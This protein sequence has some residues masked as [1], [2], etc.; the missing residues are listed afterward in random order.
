MRHLARQDARVLP[1]KSHLF[2]CR[3]GW[4]M[5]SKSALA[6]KIAEPRNDVRRSSFSRDSSH[7]DR[8]EIFLTGAAKKL[9]AGRL[10]SVR[11][12]FVS[13][14]FYCPCQMALRVQRSIAEIC[15]TAPKTP[16]SRLSFKGTGKRYE[17]MV[18]YLRGYLHDQ[19]RLGQF[20]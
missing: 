7:I 1:L 19:W 15:R 12:G 5:P 10:I 8:N 18:D 13:H 2:T 3:K 6:A 9:R 11:S 14:C 17:R 20:R 16:A 4:R